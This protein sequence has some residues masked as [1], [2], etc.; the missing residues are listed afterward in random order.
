MFDDNKP[1]YEPYRPQ[2]PAIEP[3]KKPEAQDVYTMPEKFI[4]KDG[5]GGKSK[6]V[7]LIVLLLIVVFGGVAYG[8]VILFNRLSTNANTNANANLVNNANINL[9]GNKNANTNLNTNTNGN[10]NLN[11]N[12]NTNANLNTNLNA[13][14]NLNLNMNSNANSNTNVSIIP[15][16]SS[17]DGDL[18]GLTDVEETLYGTNKSAPDTDGD[19]YIDGKKVQ[20][21]GD[22]AGELYLGYDPAVRN[23]RLEGSTLVKRYTNSTYNWSI[24]YPA[25]WTATVT[26]AVLGDKSIMFSPD[27][28]TVEYIHVTVQENMTGLSAKEWYL[29][30]NSGVSASEVKS[31]VVNGLDG[32]RSLDDTTVYLSHGDKIYVITYSTGN[33]AAVNYLTTFEMMYQ[34]FKLVSTNLTNTNTSTNS[35]ANI[36]V[37]TNANTNANTNT[38]TN[39]NSNL[40]KATNVNVTL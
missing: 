37:N 12:T 21:S 19:G 15:P 36:N 6:K 16:T 17:T 40:N 39:A 7:L 25:K 20:A 5:K 10:L 3:E 11:T 22:I 24:L 34:S 14:A 18:D 9:N 13:N 4:S 26:S 30:Q 1:N 27:I 32:V 23:G 38:N 2:P 33:L 8:A 28:S 31:L 35:N 29:S